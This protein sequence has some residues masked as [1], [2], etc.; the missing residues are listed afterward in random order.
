[1]N[2]AKLC[3]FDA[4]LYSLYA[5]GL[6]SYD[7]ALSQAKSDFQLRRA[8]L[9]FDQNARV[10]D[11]VSDATGPLPAYTVVAPSSASSGLPTGTL[12]T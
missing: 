11:P 4:K 8:L 2:T 9:A 3:E 5:V 10:R 1:M 6:L 7:E 12:P